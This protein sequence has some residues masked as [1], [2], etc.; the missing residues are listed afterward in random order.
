[1]IGHFKEVR[2]VAEAKSLLDKLGDMVRENPDK[3]EWNM[4]PKDSRYNAEILELLDQV[5]S[6]H[7][8]WN[9]HNFFFLLMLTFA[10]AKKKLR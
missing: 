5:A 1:M 10:S 9:W 6:I 3:Y 7:L 8:R 4:D 2:D